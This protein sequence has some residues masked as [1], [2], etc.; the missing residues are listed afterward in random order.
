MRYPRDVPA[1]SP[2]LEGFRAAFRR[3]AVSL[4]E[5]AWRWSAGAIA[6]ALAAFGAFEYLATLPVNA[7]EILF[8]QTRQPILVAQAIAHIL[9]GGWN[10][11]VAAGLLGA[12]AL[13]LLWM[14]ASSLGRMA[15]LRALLD[16]FRR[17]DSHTNSSQNE[18]NAYARDFRS[19]FRL[20]FLRLVVVIA[21][22]SGLAG[23]GILAGFASSVSEQNPGVAFLIF[24]FF[25]ALVCLASWTLNWF[26]S[27]AAVFAVRDAQDAVASISAAVSLCR[28]RAGAVFAVS[29][30]TGLTHL[31][32][33]VVASSVVVMP[34]A[35]AGVVSS[36]VIVL[37][38]ALV[39]LFYFCVADWIYIARLAGYVC[40]AE[41]P[42]APLSFLPP[43]PQTP[44][45]TTIDREELILSDLPTLAPEA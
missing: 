25:A 21:A 13:A 11:A 45:Q 33:F 34:L 6:I 22:V 12:L 2:T 3:P 26:L 42:N 19:L 38:M 15:T 10:R 41:M 31:A 36:R 4:A 1:I 7:G 29:F 9:R 40:I 32:T 44:L 16:Y 30:W 18:N 23:A 20:S 28:E 8:L 37:M 5:I 39:T 43:K 24:V 17:E 27:L 14:F 35:L